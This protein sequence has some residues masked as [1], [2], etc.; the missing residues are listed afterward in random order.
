MYRRSILMLNR[1]IGF[2]V[3]LSIL[4]VSPGM[5]AVQAYTD[6]VSGKWYEPGLEYCTEHGYVSGY[7][8][9]SF[10]PNQG[11]TRAE[12]AVIIN[13][14]A[15]NQGIITA[16]VARNEIS[17]LDVI[18]GAWYAQAVRNCIHYGLM[19]GYGN[20]RFGINDVLT[21]EQ[22]AV[23]LIKDLGIC[24]SQNPYV[25]FED[26]KSIHSWARLSVEL[27][28]E[29]GLMVGTGGQLFEPLKNVT[30]AEL[31][32]MIRGADQL[33][34]QD[35]AL[36]NCMGFGI[37]LSY[38]MEEYYYDHINDQMNNPFDCPGMGDLVYSSLEFSKPEI[39][40]RLMTAYLI[41]YRINDISEEELIAS[42]YALIPGYD[43]I[44]PSLDGQQVITRTESGYH[45]GGGNFGEIS[46]SVKTVDEDEDGTILVTVKTA[47]PYWEKEDGPVIRREEDR[48]RI[49]LCPNKHQN[50]RTTG[51]EFSFSVM[52]M[53]W[54]V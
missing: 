40:W 15:K 52:D 28:A 31:V 34:Y 32:T 29:Y 26:G 39:F 53:E 9:G 3:A 22:A 6:T 5:L 33:D 50:P 4:M 30:R 49:K 8:D 41:E 44:I 18:D 21:R 12:F 19:K 24:Y 20:N 16:D 7:P 46:K 1:I 13:K 25:S 10:R 35:V 42:A 2:A 51:Y 47:G 17:F 45:F 23:I 36:E 48:W 43:G 54:I 37:A 14:V 11:I 27:A 38:F